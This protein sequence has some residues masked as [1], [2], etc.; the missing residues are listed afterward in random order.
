[1]CWYIYNCLLYVYSFLFISNM[2]IAIIKSVGHVNWNNNE[3][4]IRNTWGHYGRL[5]Y[6]K[7]IALNIVEKKRKYLV[8]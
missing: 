2:S 7:Q 3:H 1:M 4:E 8:T 6:V 5:T